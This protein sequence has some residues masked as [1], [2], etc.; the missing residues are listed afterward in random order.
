MATVRSFGVL[1]SPEGKKF[2]RNDIKTNRLTRVVIAGCSPKEHEPTFQE[3]LKDANLN[4][5]LLQV[6]NI[7][8]QCA[9]VISDRKA[10]TDKA[11]ALVRAAINRVTRHE[12][13]EKREIACCVDLLVIGAGVAGVSAALAVAQR[14]RSVYLIVKRT[15]HRGQGCPS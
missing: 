3:I 12:P 2:L 7:R 10:A 8:E 5:F 4:P 9:W 6:A 13:I 14:N 11:L 15:L 1:C